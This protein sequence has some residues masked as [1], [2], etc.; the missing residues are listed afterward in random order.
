M[1]P[2]IKTEAWSYYVSD[3]N[4]PL[5]QFEFHSTIVALWNQKREG[6]RLPAWSDFELM[7]L[8]EWWGWLTVLDQLKPDGS[9]WKYRLWGTEVARLTGHE[10]TGKT[11]RQQQSNIVEFSHYN[12]QDFE[13]LKVLTDQRKIGLLEGPVKFELETFNWVS[14]I[15]LPLSDDGFRIDKFLSAVSP[16]VPL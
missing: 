6:D 9:D 4:A 8:K 5:S 11:L 15:R 3:L 2:T 1:E 13:H 12:D 14:I 7:D 10:M 16:R